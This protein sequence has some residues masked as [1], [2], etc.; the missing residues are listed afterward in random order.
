MAWIVAKTIINKYP[1]FMTVKNRL[2]TAVIGTSLLLIAVVGRLGWGSSI[3]TM[4]GNTSPEEWNKWLF[5]MFSTL[6]TFLIF[7][8]RFCTYLYNRLQAH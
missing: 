6:G 4:E 8:E 2:I 7:V 5:W 3:V 1:Y